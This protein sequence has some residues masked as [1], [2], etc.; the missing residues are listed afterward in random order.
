LDA[1]NENKKPRVRDLMKSLIKAQFESE[2]EGLE[3]RLDDRP[4]ADPKP[5]KLSRLVAKRALNYN[6]FKEPGLNPEK[7]SADAIIDR[8]SEIVDQTSDIC[9]LEFWKSHQS[10]FPVLAKLAKKYLS[11]QA[12]SAAVERMFS[13]AGHIFAP[14]RR[15]LKTTI[16]SHLVYVKLNENYI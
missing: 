2:N 14:K 13:I 4:I 10:Q 1:F 11:V 16:Y 12:S 6:L 5:N 15:K 9:A 3:Y 7:D 8:Y